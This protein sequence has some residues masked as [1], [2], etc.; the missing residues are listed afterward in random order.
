[1]THQ[2]AAKCSL[3]YN[4]GKSMPGIY[5][6][7]FIF[8]KSLEK[9]KKKSHESI[10]YK[11]IEILFSCPEN[12]KTGLLGAIGPNIF[13]YMHLISRDSFYGNEISFYLHDFAY[14]SFI[15]TLID[16]IKEKGDFQTEWLSAQ[17]SYL[18]GY[19]SH[20]IAD[21]FLHPYVFYSSGFPDEDDTNKKFY[22]KSNLRFQYNIDNY[23]LYRDKSFTREDLEVSSMIPSP[24][25]K[26][27]ALSWISARNLLLSGLQ[28][29]NP[30][31][32]KKYFKKF[33]NE[34]LDG[35]F[36]KTTPLDKVLKNIPLC[37]RLKRS[38]N[39][40]VIKIID[41]FEKRQSIIYSDFFI[42][43]PSP[44][45]V[46]EDALNIHQGRWQYPAFQRGFRYDSV[47]HL[48]NH[49]IESIV[50]AWG[51]LEKYFMSCDEKITLS[52][53]NPYTGEKEGHYR[54]MEIKEP[55][56][57]KV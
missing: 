36:T 38:E 40:R 56:K 41:W 45:R 13:D 48:T 33:L 8:R 29:E 37:Y 55:I 3:S 26:K 28:R 11:S 10:I 25:N 53:V 54:D 34:K 30:E 7:N 21:S 51:I 20:I 17:R 4:Q 2:E 6:H 18:F 12:I 44:K 9:V 16:I 1:L 46:D 42:R 24:Y 43:Y 35:T 39:H 57:I 32:F 15:F 47:I 31:L 22:R 5:T 52:F 50:E 49:A 27:E 14:E 19:I 23:Y